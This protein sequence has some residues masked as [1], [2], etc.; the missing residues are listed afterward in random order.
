MD[1]GF[2]VVL[3]AVLGVIV[4]SSVVWHFSRSRSLLKQWVD[5]SGPSL[6]A[7]RIR[8]ALQ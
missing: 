4:M 1:S 5:V 2:Q 8:A 7:L 6:V 3:F